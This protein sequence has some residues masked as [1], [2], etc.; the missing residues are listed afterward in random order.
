MRSKFHS[1]PKVD[2]SNPAE[3]IQYCLLLTIFKKEHILQERSLILILES[4]S[5]RF[6]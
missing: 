2:G 3:W 5:D 1:N 6:H 4:L